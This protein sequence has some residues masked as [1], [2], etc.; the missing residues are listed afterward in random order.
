MVGTVR[1]NANELVDL[2]E[3]TDQ[4][5]NDT[6]ELRTLLEQVKEGEPEKV[7]RRTRPAPTDE[8]PTAQERLEFEAGH[9][10]PAGIT[11]DILNQL[12]EFDGKYSLKELRNMCVEAGLSASGHKKLLAAKLLAR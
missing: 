6:T 8:E 10:F 12:I 4:A 2:I 7:R 9:L 11:D 3:A 1:L 5:G